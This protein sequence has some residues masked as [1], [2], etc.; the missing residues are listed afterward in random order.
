MRSDRVVLVN[1]IEGIGEGEQRSLVRWMRFQRQQPML[2][3]LG[4]RDGSR[5]RGDC[6]F[7]SITAAAALDNLQRFSG[8]VNV[9][10]FAKYRH[11]AVSMVLGQRD[12]LSGCGRS[13][14]L[15]RLQRRLTISGDLEG[16]SPFH[17]LQNNN[18][19]QSAWRQYSVGEIQSR[20]TG[21]RV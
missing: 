15:R 18:S 12:E 13:V 5:F 2:S 10:H 8:W 17:I 7:W 3:D 19:M 9:L 20:V 16:G 6:R 11:P 14:R 1:D 4:R 21:D